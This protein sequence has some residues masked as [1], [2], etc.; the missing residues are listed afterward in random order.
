M[1]SYSYRVYIVRFVICIPFCQ[2]SC[3]AWLVSSV[4][5]FIFVKGMSLL[6]ESVQFICWWT[7]ASVLHFRCF[8]SLTKEELAID[9]IIFRRFSFICA[10]NST[11][12]RCWVHEWFLSEEGREGEKKRGKEWC[13][14]RRKTFVQHES[15]MSL[16]HWPSHLNSLWTYP[17]LFYFIQRLWCILDKIVRHLKCTVWW[18][19]M[20]THVY[21][22]HCE[23]IELTHLSP[24]I[25]T[26]FFFF[27]WDYVLPHILHR[28]GDSGST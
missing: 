16:C 27:F 25:L 23:S 4:W 15:L 13:K 22:I 10:F 1:N 14:E 6:F 3:L 2:P 19:D 17:L 21:R 28:S 24:H 11:W 8:M 9:Q 20:Y 18:F 7:R 12:Y 26:F 5:I